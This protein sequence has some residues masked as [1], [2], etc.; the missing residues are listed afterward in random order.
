M[1]PGLLNGILTGTLDDRER[2]SPV[3]VGL[4]VACVVVV[5]LTLTWTFLGM[6]AVMDVGGSCAEGGPYQIA[7]PC[8]DGAVLLSAAIPVMLVS[9]MLG[10]ALA[11]LSR[12]PNLLVPMWALLFGSLGWNFLEYGFTDAGPVWGW[13][14]CGVVFEA[15]ALPAVV[16]VVAGSRLRG[17]IPAVRDDAPAPRLTWW[18]GYLILGVVGLAL[19]AWS[20]D[21][22]S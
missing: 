13:V 7:Q 11:L 19:G 5:A 12:A 10:S 17:W 9:A 4:L 22:W 14:V 21:A 1:S 6:R 18:L 2:R 8:P 3:V 15:M 20:F 16:V